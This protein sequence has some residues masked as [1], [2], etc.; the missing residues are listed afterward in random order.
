MKVHKK[1]VVCLD[2]DGTLIYDDKY[3]LGKTNDWRSK[4]KILPK[5]IQGIKILRKI[6]NVKIYMITNQPGVAVKNFRLLTSKRAHEVCKYVLKK[7][8]EK[9]AKLDDYFLCDHATPNYVKSHQD[10]KFER[11]L[12]CNCNCIKPKLGMVFD[13]LKLEGVKKNDVK[14]YVIG[15][16]LSDVKTGI[17]AKG[18]GILV[19]FENE[20]T[21]IEKVSKVKGS[22]YISKNFLDA[23]RYIKNRE[24]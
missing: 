1:I 9:G 3:Y 24:K 4:V 5:V 14:I 21:N 13:A 6:P 18:T 20:P 2:R 8:E 17:N 23:T 11:K 22:K 15:D 12:V 19:P 10:M 7:L 16:R